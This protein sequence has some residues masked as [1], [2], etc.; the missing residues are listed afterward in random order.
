MPFGTPFCAPKCALLQMSDR[1]DYQWY[2]GLLVFVL[3]TQEIPYDSAESNRM[4]DLV[5]SKRVIVTPAVRDLLGDNIGE[6]G[7]LA[8]ELYLMAQE[9]K[10][11]DYLQVFMNSEGEDLWILEDDERITVMT[12]SDW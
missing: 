11:L 1:L 8:A 7:R 3:K 4:F 5:N 9:C 2:S 12:P 10:G 6:A